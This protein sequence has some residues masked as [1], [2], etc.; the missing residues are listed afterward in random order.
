MIL[1]PP[2]APSL[3]VSDREPAPVGSR[4]EELNRST[5]GQ[6]ELF[7]S[8]REQVERLI[9]HHL[10]QPHP[11][12]LELPR[13]RLCALGAGNC[14][15]LDLRFLCDRVGEVHLV[16]IDAAALTAAM[17]RQKA[18][19]IAN[20]RR[21]APFDLAAPNSLPDRLG[22]FDIVLSSCV[23]SQLIAGVRE[24][25]GADHPDFPSQRTKMVTQQLWLMLRLLAP[26]GCGILINDLVS[27]D[28]AKGLRQVPPDDLPS[29]M[30]RLVADGKTF[31]ELDPAAITGALDR[32]S[33]TGKR[34]QTRPWLWHLSALRSYLVYGLVFRMD[35]GLKTA[36]GRRSDRDS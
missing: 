13:T 23:L 25:L 19:D 24:R 1:E 21:H 8:H 2:P 5:R 26:G 22:R 3:R 11:L 33:S 28:T 30:Q 15:D 31:R 20:L 32:L 16:D 35:T 34:Y 14:N 29:L 4:S 17:A 36:S 18:E 7:R 6:W 10:P 9:L 27:S 12:L